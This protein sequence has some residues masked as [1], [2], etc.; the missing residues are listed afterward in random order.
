MAGVGLPRRARAD[1]F[2]ASRFSTHVHEVCLYMTHYAYFEEPDDDVPPAIYLDVLTG[3]V[4]NLMNLSAPV[5]EQHFARDVPDRANL[6][7]VAPATSK[8]MPYLLAPP[9]FPALPAPPA[10]VGA[11]QAMLGLPAALIQAHTRVILM[12]IG[13]FKKHGEPTGK[14]AGRSLRIQEDVHF[15][16]Q[17]RPV[18]LFEPPPYVPV[19]SVGV[20]AP[21]VTLADLHGLLGLAP[22]AVGGTDIV[23]YSWR[24]QMEL[25]TEN[26]YIRSTASEPVPVAKPF[27]PDQSEVRMVGMHVD[28]TGMYSVVGSVLHPEF[29]APPILLQFLFGTTNLTDVEFVVEE[30]GMLVPA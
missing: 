14:L 22:P 5:M 25:S 9:G 3:G 13:E 2:G 11:I 1:V 26:R 18:F 19:P 28:D 30:M 21:Y 8:I 17:L 24:S 15:V 6:V 27:G 10:V 7:S 23:T 29:D 12:A 16:V 4:T 20:I